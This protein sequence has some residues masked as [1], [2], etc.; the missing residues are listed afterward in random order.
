MSLLVTMAMLALLTVVSG[1][2]AAPA[3]AQDEPLPIVFVHGFMGSGAQYRAQAM[4]FA[5]NGWPAERIRAIDYSGLSPADL[6][7]FIDDVREEFGV[8][9]VYAAG[10][11]LGTA[12]MLSYLLGPARS[13]KVE[14]YAA[15]DGVGAF[16]LWGTRCTSITAASMDQSH[17]EAST[18]PES[19][20]RQ[21][22]HFTGEAPATTDVVP[23]PPDQVEIGGKVLDFV[24]NVPAT[25]ASGE[26]WEIDPDTGARLGD[27]PDETFDVDES[28]GSFGP[29]P[30]NGDA[31]YEIAV[32]RDGAGTISYYYQPFTRSSYLMRL[33][34]LPPGS[35]VIE[36]TNFGPDH[37]AGVVLRYR[38]WWNS[39]TLEVSTSSASG[40]EAPVDVL[41]SID[42]ENVVGIHIHDTEASPGSTTLDPISY[43]D[44]QAFQAG[45][46]VYMPG[47]SPPDGTISFVNVPRGD[48]GNLQEINIANHGSEDDAGNPH[49]F[50]VEFN[51][52]A[53]DINTWDE[54]VQ[55]DAC[56]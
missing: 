48:A 26:L 14:A 55:A 8:D 29:L 16:C 34:S 6:D 31:N 28:D 23:E 27:A 1:T 52:Y 56:G 11:S 9:Q 33:Q 53:Q 32:E 24:D 17:V 19:F 50:A 12:V 4:R 20:A 18:S 40:N 36:N 38:E 5:S 45:R 43:F 51:D 30:V 37:A 42:A 22:E 54:C 2:G 7:G 35:A 41:S 49:G 47:S 21:Y 3:E 39:D 10:H 25:G 13:A 44:S 46:D 15:L